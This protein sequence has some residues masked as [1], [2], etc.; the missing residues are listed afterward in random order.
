MSAVKIIRFGV[1]P[2]AP[3]SSRPG[4]VTDGDPMTTTH[5]YYTDSSNRFFSGIWES[6]PGK[7]NC[8]YSESEFVYPDLGPGP[9]DRRRRPCGN[10]RPRQRLRHPC[11]VQGQL[12]DSGD[13]EE[14]LRDLQLR[15]DRPGD[16]FP[17]ETERG[18]PAWLFLQRI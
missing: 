6:T 13:P 1:N 5:N 10:L 14:V 12:G 4:N 11:R 7:W 2:P 16:T 9:A 18:P 3:E 15:P 17:P 8:D